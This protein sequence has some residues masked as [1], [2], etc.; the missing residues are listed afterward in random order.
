LEQKNKK[1]KLGRDNFF[2]FAPEVKKITEP[3]P[4]SELA[5]QAIEYAKEL[6]MIV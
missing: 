5:E 4:S 1:W 2:H 3:I 6:E